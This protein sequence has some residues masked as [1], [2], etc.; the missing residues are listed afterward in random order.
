MV[1]GKALQED[2]EEEE[3][4]QPST[5]ELARQQ[6]KSK[7]AK[8]VAQKRTQGPVDRDDTGHAAVPMQHPQIGEFLLVVI[9]SNDYI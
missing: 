4:K 3:D 8:E 2:E 9:Y 6:R 5:A 1:F 7:K